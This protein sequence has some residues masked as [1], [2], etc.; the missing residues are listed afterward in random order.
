MSNERF[1]F[2]NIFS[3]LLALTE[4][5]QAIHATYNWLCQTASD[6]E[7][8]RKQTRSSEVRRQ[9]KKGRKRTNDKRSEWVNMCVFVCVC[10]NVQCACTA[11]TST[12]AT[13]PSYQWGF[14]NQRFLHLQP[15]FSF[16]FFHFLVFA[17]RLFLYF[18]FSQQN[19]IERY[20]SHIRV[21][22]LFLLS[23]L[24]L[25]LLLASQLVHRFC[26]VMFSR[27][28]VTYGGIVKDRTDFE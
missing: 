13:A 1:P 28:Y 5:R 16:A 2:N 7:R 24:L 17:R 26:F 12:M 14:F 18:S 15:F 23:M 25:L 3:S 22:R 21:V 8:R 9:K 4:K 11:T 19:S 6:R 10:V 27:M 20:V